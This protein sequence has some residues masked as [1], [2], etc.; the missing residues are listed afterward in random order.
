MSKDG[1]MVDPSKIEVIMD[2]KVPS[3]VHEIR[4]FLGLLV[5]IGTSLRGSQS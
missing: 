3:S 1:I 2:W 5:I 4:S